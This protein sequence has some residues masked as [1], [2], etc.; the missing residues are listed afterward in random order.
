MQVEY[1]AAQVMP[2]VLMLR[3]P[4]PAS[5]SIFL[6]Y[7]SK[8]NVI[9][10]YD[11]LKHKHFLVSLCVAGLTG[12]PCMFITSGSTSQHRWCLPFAVSLHL[13]NS[14]HAFS[15]LNQLCVVA[16]LHLKLLSSRIN[17]VK[18]PFMECLTQL[19][20]SNGL[21][22][23]PRRLFFLQ[24]SILLLSRPLYLSNLGAHVCY[25]SHSSHSLEL[26][27]P[28]LSR[29]KNEILRGERFYYRLYTWFHP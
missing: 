8:W 27:W 24:S 19:E 23:Q 29:P 18:L 15:S 14:V 12:S 25:E 21:W 7:L 22:L 2:W 5:Q 9:S 11:S 4:T 28:F 13:S 1:R 26:R 3:G 10:L 6:D 17:Y 16:M 20:R